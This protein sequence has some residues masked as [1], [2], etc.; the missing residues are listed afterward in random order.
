MPSMSNSLFAVAVA[1]DCADAAA[2]ARFWADVL[3]RQVAEGGTSERTVLLAGGGD[4]SGPCFVFNRVPEAKTVKN[5]LHLDI[6]SDTFPAE[7]ERLL[8]LGAR[9]LRDQQA[10][11]THW[12]TFADIEGNEFDLI[13]G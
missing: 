1:I 9:R 4:I 10:S 12:T 2:L 8:R 3:G 11:T 13:A 7:A 6:I 5:R